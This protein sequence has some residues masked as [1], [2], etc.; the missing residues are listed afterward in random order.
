M[1]ATATEP[2]KARKGSSPKREKNLWHPTAEE[3]VE[4]I[5]D[6]L[7]SVLSMLENH[8]LD[9]K[10]IEEE[11]GEIDD[12]QSEEGR[13]LKVRHY[14]VEQQIA[15]CRAWRDSLRDKLIQTITEAR[16]GKLIELGNEDLER[17]PA[18]EKQLTLHPKEAPKW[19]ARPCELDLA[20]PL[21]AK[22]AKS[23]LITWGQVE[24]RSKRKKGEGLDSL[25]ELTD[26]E[27]QQVKAKLA[28]YQKETATAGE[29][30]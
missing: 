19:H 18:D 8:I 13:E 12:K 9:R 30:A 5:A 20:G 6:R 7:E 23:Q 25:D 4:K 21:A 14:D 1:T 17:P 22:L 24:Q 27:R 26:E 10:A 16:Q 2:K 3:R 15:S 29:A 11:L 28:L